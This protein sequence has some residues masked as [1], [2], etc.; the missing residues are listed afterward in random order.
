MSINRLLYLLIAIT[1]LTVTACAPQAVSKPTPILTVEPQPTETV[2]ATSLPTPIATETPV[3]IGTLNGCVPACMLGLTRP[4]NLPPGEYQTKYFFGGR[5]QVT[6]DGDWRS[7]EDSTGEFH[8]SPNGSNNDLLFWEDVY[9]LEN[10]TRVED[11]PMTAAGL[12]D[13]LSGS[14]R[15]KTTAP[16]AG[17][18]GETI[19]ATIVDVSI[20][21]GAPNEDPGC[22]DVSCI[23]FLGFPQWDAPWGIAEPQIQRFYI[24]DVSYGGA[25]HLFV[26]V[27][28]P[29]N[30]AD[31]ESH[32]LLAE[33]VIASVRVPV[34]E[35]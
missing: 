13:W 11:V 3:V 33:P 29:D 12:L 1:L 27:I 16:V 22:V 28:Y 8:L 5:M 4:G 35:N 15:L 10:E 14:P 18:I 26:A 6:L 23:L 9:P 34:D 24:A 31:L 17:H 21:K 30:P 7:R 2:S 32:R 25:S 19:P 20:A